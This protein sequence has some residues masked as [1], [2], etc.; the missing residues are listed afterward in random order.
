MS[1]GHRFAV[2][3]VTGVIFCKEFRSFHFATFTVELLDKQSHDT[4]SV[5]GS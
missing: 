3:N 2:P 4:M 5:K 1:G